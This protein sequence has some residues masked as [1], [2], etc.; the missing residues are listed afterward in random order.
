MKVIGHRGWPTRYPD[1]VIE[2]IAAAFE[3]AEMVEVDIRVSG[4]GHLVLS[5]DPV[6]GGLLVAKSSWQALSEVEL[7]GGFQPVR[8]EDLLEIFPA[9]PFN[10]EVKNSPGEPGF[11]PDHDIA[12][13]VA[14]L[15][16]AGDLLSCFNWP[17]M[18]A[19]RP[20]FPG[21]A[22]GLLADV[23]W[24][25]AGA[26]DHALASG[27]VAVI[28]HW[29]LALSSGPSCQVADAAGLTV[30]VWTLNDPSRLDELASIGVTAIITD[31]PGEMRR[32]I[33]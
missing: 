4:D 12:C 3:V 18:D 9:S 30:A 13:R 1:N 33:G 7:A 16:R 31:N 28:P 11:D 24:D 15:A 17:A 20:E 25:V 10:L 21:V 6:L 19:V 22:T 14:A 26:V 8:L 29:E 5:H 27:H 32:V 23:G 2:G